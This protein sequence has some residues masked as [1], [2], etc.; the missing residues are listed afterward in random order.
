MWSS[1]G[2]NYRCWAVII[3][4]SLVIPASAVAQT[5][6]EL[7]RDCSEEALAEMARDDLTAAPADT[8]VLSSGLT[9][10]EAQIYRDR[11]YEVRQRQIAQF[12][13][14]LAEMPP[15]YPRRADVL[16]RLAEAYWEVEEGNYLAIRAEYNACMDDWMRCLRD[17]VC[18]EPLP[19]YSLALD[20]YREILRDHPDYER[21][22]EV[23][24]RLGDGL[25]QA[26][27]A[28]DGI[29]FLARLINNYED[30]RY[31][32][33]AYFL[34]GDYF[35]EGGVMMAAR[36][37][38]E[39]VLEYPQCDYYEFSIYK[40]AWVDMNDN[41]WEEAVQRFQTVISNID[42][43]AARGEV[44]RF[45]LRPQALNDMLVAWT[46][47]EDGWIQARL[48]L[49]E[50]QDEETMR[51]K[52]MAMSDLYDEKGKDEER[53]ALIEWF[54]ETYPNDSQLVTW[55]EYLRDSLTK[56]GQW[57]RYEERMRR[58]V[59]GFDPNGTWAIVN[60]E[61]ERVIGMARQFSE[62]TFLAIILRNYAECVRLSRNELCQEVA[63]DYGEFF[64]RWPDSDHAY[65]Q[66]FNWA[67]VLYYNV[68][69]H[70]A[71]GEQYLEVVR[72]DTEGEHAHDAAVGALQAFDDLMET[73]V[74]DIDDERAMLTEETAAEICE[75]EPEE[76]GHWSARY[77]EVVGYFAELFPEDELIPVASWRAAELYRRVNRLG[78][79]AARFETIIEYHATNRYAEEAAISAFLC[80]QCVENWVK[81]ESIARIMLDR[82]LDNPELNADRLRDAIAYAISQ[83]TEDLMEAGE[84]LQAAELMLA[85]YNEFPDSEFSPNAL[86]N[87]AAI[88]ERARRMDTAI[89][90]YMT[91][92]EAYPEDPNIPEAKLVL[93]YI[94]DS[95]A[96]FAQAADWFETVMDYPDF[97][98]YSSAILNAAR[99]REALSEFDRAIDLY[100][101]YMEL[102]PDDE[103]NAGRLFLL[104]RIEHNR[105]NV[106]AAYDRYDEFRTTY[107]GAA[108]MQIAARAYQARIRVEEGNDRLATNLYEEIVDL[109]GAGVLLFDE[110]TGLPTEWESVPGWR[111]EDAELRSKALPFAAEATFYL[112]E[113]VFRTCQETTLAYPEG[114]WRA[115]AQNLQ[116]RGTALDAAQRK[117]F[118][119]IEM[120]DAA[121]S[122][123]ATTRIGEL[124]SKFYDDMY[125]LPPPDIDECYDRGYNPDDCDAMD[126]QYNDMMYNIMY[127][128]ETK[129]RESFTEALSIAHDNNIY[130][131][132]TNRGVENLMAIDRS[133]QVHG[134]EGVEPTNVDSLFT[135]AGYITDISDRLEQL[136][137]EY[138]ERQR[139]LRQQQRQQQGLPVDRAVDE[140][141]EPVEDVE[142]DIPLQTD[143]SGTDEPEDEPETDE[144]G[145][146]EPEDEPETEDDGSGD[147]SQN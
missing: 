72:M 63:A 43:L 111:F 100:D 7:Y 131:E 146:D 138:E 104:A 64:D 115:L 29:Q 95:Q 34:R 82:N 75:R 48:Y 49:T 14:M 103:D 99:L 22:D 50:T 118:E 110:A 24:F 96:E 52:L 74:P 122:V 144:S 107:P 135:G 26:G 121:W 87:A 66:R 92:L 141:T 105:G 93:G 39:H 137:R 85:L 98:E 18:E 70:P 41:W 56:I 12:L 130:T 124:Y 65:E 46:E 119:V 21:I 11:I 120:R 23:I 58:L 67:E 143:E 79:A 145:T 147:V 47:V 25:I 76:L 54:A 38:Y 10:E 61:N 36:D 80:Y 16:F 132:W 27:E 114:R 8:T 37:N 136:R 33:D 55:A 90:T 40:L 68:E 123:A 19:D 2:R 139:L 128:I 86:F 117:M 9:P 44:V 108:W 69:D 13:D 112:A 129:A 31:I 35:F 60:S 17:E 4:L 73:E 106:D 62:E 101:Q 6:D 57:D 81:I 84:E 134:E 78:D 83:Q 1:K 89:N 20:Q 71:A 94:Y 53:V 42:A 28:A 140:V 133:I 91:F 5:E 126:E 125:A 88:Y 30:S 15:D 116:S 113:P 97:E 59:R 109:Y 45:D 32:P 51:R 142:V 127:P 102:V 77:V 3:A